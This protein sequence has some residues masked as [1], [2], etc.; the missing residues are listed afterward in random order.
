MD[1]SAG[2]APS[3]DLLA[4][5]RTRHHESQPVR[6][7]RSFPILQRLLYHHHLDHARY[8]SEHELRGFAFCHTA[9]PHHA[10][11]QQAR[12]TATTATRAKRSAARP[13]AARTRA[14][15]TT[16]L[17][18]RTTRC[19]RVA[20]GRRRAFRTC[21]WWSTASRYGTAQ[22][23][24]GHAR[25]HHAAQHVSA[26]LR[27]TPTTTHCHR[28][29]SWSTCDTPKLYVPM[30]RAAGGRGSDRSVVRG[31]RAAHVAGG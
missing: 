7:V 19:G 5:G 20:A 18:T 23:G 21:W 4:V 10:T 13:R 3:Q 28:H 9:I 6:S 30:P 12:S 25:S 15:R 31:E 16:A 29:T 1:Q 8:D 2:A 27:T 14:V 11:R 24:T 22:D 17:T 26:P